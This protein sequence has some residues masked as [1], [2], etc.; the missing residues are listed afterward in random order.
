MCSACT[1]GERVVGAERFSMECSRGVLSFY[2][3]DLTQPMSFLLSQRYIHFDSKQRF[4][5]NVIFEGYIV[6]S[7][8]YGR[9][10]TSCLREHHHDALP[11]TRS[12]DERLCDPV[13]APSCT[14][15]G[16][17]GRVGHEE[18]VDHCS[19]FL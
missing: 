6:S 10:T 2:P 4:V 7:R 16:L 5:Q 18:G 17:R 15:S 19:A 9:L 8:L 14:M 13:G 1:F 3:R 11:A 12:D